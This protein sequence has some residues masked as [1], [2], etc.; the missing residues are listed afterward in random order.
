MPHGTTCTA[1]SSLILAATAGILASPADVLA[2]RGGSS[3]GTTETEP[4]SSDTLRTFQP[5]DLLRLHR[6]GE[7]RFSP[8]GRMLAFERA[9]SAQEGPIDRLPERPEPRSDIWIAS[10]GDDEARRLT[11]GHTDGA[12]WFQPRWSPDGERLAFLSIDGN[13]IRAWVWERS[14]DEIRR[15]TDQPVH[16]NSVG[17]LVFRWLSA[18]ELALA[19]RPEGAPERSRMLAD[20]TRPGLYATRKWEA[21]WSGKEVT[22]DVLDADPGNA[23]AAALPLSEIRIY[24]VDGGSEQSSEGRFGLAWPSPEG[25]W[26]ATFSEPPVGTVASGQ[27]IHQWSAFGTRPGAAPLAGGNG[28]GPTQAPADE[29]LHQPFYN[30]LQWA[31]DGSAYAFLFQ[32]AQE[33]GASPGR[34][35]AVYRPVSGELRTFGNPDTRIGALA[36]TG[37]SRLLVRAVRPTES[38]REA[39]PDWW[40]VPDQGEWQNL[41]AGITDVPGELVP[42]PGG[43]VGIAD[44]ELWR[45]GED[46]EPERLMD[47]LDQKLGAIVW[48]SASG[49][50]SGGATSLRSPA[51]PFGVLATSESGREIIVVEPQGPDTREIVRIPVPEG[52]G[53]PAD[54]APARAAAAF[55]RSDD[56]GTWLFRQQGASSAGPADPDTLLA[57]DRWLARIEPGQSRKL[58]YPGPEGDELTAWILLPP[59]HQDGQRHPTVVWFYPGQS[60]RDRAPGATRLNRPFAIAALQL[61]ASRGYAVLFPSVPLGSDAPGRPNLAEFI[62]PA[63]DEA[64]ENGLTDGERLGA[65]GHSY[66]GYGVNH[67]ISQ[68]DRFQ[69]AVSSAGAS[70]LRS[71]FGTLDARGRYGHMDHPEALQ[72]NVMGYFE[73]G[74]GRM[75]APPYRVPERYRKASPL[76]WV[77]EIDT[78]LLMIHG[79]QDFVP[80]QQAEMMFTELLRQ[81]K[82]ARLVRYAGEDHTVKGGANVLD[83][84]EQIF[85]WWEAFLVEQ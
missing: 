82:R 79:D 29:N 70:H 2:A 71:H 13:R 47:E 26:L 72:L 49:F 27:P 59:D 80:I 83:M 25:R 43:A 42:V 68:T 44:G 53:S 55:S 39:R 16:L 46:Q 51:E 33:E 34:R 40:H 85:A 31:P 23:P 48:P 1:L 77:E 62:L 4:A 63:V 18:E 22:A 52:E 14:T 78:P 73:S 76:T 32:P 50:L 84:W 41:T 6:V 38:D 12:G 75:G 74:Q 69:A 15:V 17:P 11:D 7:V 3:I 37:D 61:L 35:L 28:A 64:V 66:G 67:L 5:E 65:M 9:R 19:V 57:E 20:F 56:T 54:V 60:Q 10:E 30:T 24:H 21:S 81:G 45:I 8:D 58:T 36:W